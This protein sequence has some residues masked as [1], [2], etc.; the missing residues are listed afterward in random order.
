VTFHSAHTITE[1][2]M[3]EMFL[4]IIKYK[5]EINKVLYDKLNTESVLS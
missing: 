2:I 4:Y 5:H 3:H 1:L